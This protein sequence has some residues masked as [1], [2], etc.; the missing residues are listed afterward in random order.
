ME[1]M[2]SIETP[3]I[4]L[5][6]SGRKNL[7]ETALKNGK[8]KFDAK[9]RLGNTALH[10]LCTVDMADLAEKAIA[11]GAD[12]SLANNAG[13]TPLHLAAANGVLPTIRLL[14]D[15]GAKINAQDMEDKTPLIY[16][17]ENDQADAA[18]YLL[19][20]GADKYSRTIT[21]L[22][23]KDFIKAAGPSMDRLLPFFEAKLTQIDSKGN[24]PLHQAVYQGGLTTVKN[25]LNSDRSSI[26]F[27][28]NKSLTP[29][30]VAVSNLNFEI[31]N[32]LLKHGADPNI[33]RPSDGNSPLHLAAENGLAW[34]G[35]ILLDHGAKIDVRNS[36]GATPL[37]LAV[38][39]QHRDFA[40]MLLRRGAD[41]FIA[42]GEGKTAPDYASESGF[43]TMEEVF[44]AQLGK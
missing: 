1:S 42:D 41:P 14:L 22:F 13:Q 31:S 18:E 26:N 15:K 20:S 34:L 29:L 17:V 7:V 8:A 5:C 16:A 44:F 30:L 21:G 37:S 39:W 28:N 9:D 10:Y 24:T 3:F 36:D 35:E 12:V 32:L 43:K 38:Q 25:L 40:T 27:K 23:P 33:S 4:R 6:Q 2:D 11:A 19:V